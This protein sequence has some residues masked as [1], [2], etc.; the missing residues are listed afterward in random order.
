MATLA[1]GIAV[2]GGHGRFAGGLYPVH[3]SGLHARTGR[4]DLGLLLSHRTEPWGMGERSDVHRTPAPSV[5][6]AIDIEMVPT[7]PHFPHK[8]LPEH[9]AQAVGPFQKMRAI[10]GD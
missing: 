1:A 9:A 5:C 6:H 3:T 7:C 4:P 10:T 8:L 2:G